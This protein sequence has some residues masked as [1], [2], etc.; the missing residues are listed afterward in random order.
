MQKSGWPDVVF[1][2]LGGLKQYVT[3]NTIESIGPFLHLTTRQ[4]FKITNVD[5]VFSAAT[6]LQP[7]QTHI[8]CVFIVMKSLH[9]RS[10]AVSLDLIEECLADDT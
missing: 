1:I 4:T 5:A 2:S 6:A 9:Q 8:S 7:L 10:T 3:V